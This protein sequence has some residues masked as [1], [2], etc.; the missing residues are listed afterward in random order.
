MKKSLFALIYILMLATVGCLAWSCSDQNDEV[1]VIIPENNLPQTAQSFITTYFP[2]QKVLKVEMKIDDNKD[3]G[4][5]VRFDNG[6]EVEFDTSGN[7][8]KVE[9]TQLR[10]VPDALVPV[11]ISEYVTTNY[12][13]DKGRIMD[14][15]REFDRT[16]NIVKWEVELYYNTTEIDFTP[17]FKVSYDE[18]QKK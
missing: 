18:G 4:Y 8:T 6:D 9:M 7:W 12:P 17:D 13:G 1:P 14:L 15:E 16:G 11:Q 2:G 3:A 10:T 5:E